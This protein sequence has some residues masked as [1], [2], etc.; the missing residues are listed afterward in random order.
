M[1]IKKIE[2]FRNVPIVELTDTIA[3]K[4]VPSETVKYIMDDLLAHTHKH[5]LTGR[6]YWAPKDSFNNM[7]KMLNYSSHLPAEAIELLFRSGI[8]K[9]IFTYDKIKF[10]ELFLEQ[11]NASIVIFFDS[12]EIITGLN[13]REPDTWNNKIQQIRPLLYLD[14]LKLITKV[15]ALNSFPQELLIS[16]CGSASDD[17]RRI[18][19]NTASCPR[20]GKVIAA[21]MG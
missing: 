16:F 3:T 8:Y 5:E 2:C 18:A 20:E 9:A 14:E 13:P 12:I 6:D 17:I 7:N 15:F 21:L 10:S 11:E 19:V 1:D 4:S